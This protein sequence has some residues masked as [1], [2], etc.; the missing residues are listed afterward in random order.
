MS[1]SEIGQKTAI[2][3][4]LNMR[5]KNNSCHRQRQ[6]LVDLSQLLRHHLA[7]RPDQLAPAEAVDRNF[8][9]L[10]TLEVDRH[11]HADF[12]SKAII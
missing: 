2:G 7:H 3:C 10:L 1:A 5:L 9:G 12:P 8:D 6:K 11:H 4:A